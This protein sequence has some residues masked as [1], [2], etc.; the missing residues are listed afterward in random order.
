[1]LFSRQLPHDDDADMQPQPAH[2]VHALPE[3]VIATAAQ[4]AGSGGTPRTSGS[5]FPAA[6]LQPRAGLLSVVD[7]VAD[8]FHSAQ[9]SRASWCDLKITR[10]CAARSSKPSGSGRGIGS[11]PLRIRRGRETAA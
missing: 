3:R 6:G 5:R 8:E 11:G 1:M 9:A 7:E 10:L 2:L 4:C